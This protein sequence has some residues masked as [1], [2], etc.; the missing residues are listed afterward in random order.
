MVCTVLFIMTWFVISFCFL[1]LNADEH[2]STKGEKRD[3]NFEDTSMH[4]QCQN[5]CTTCGRESTISYEA[6]R[7]QKLHSVRKS[8]DSLQCGHCVLHADNLKCHQCKSSEASGGPTGK[9]L[10]L[11]CSPR[12]GQERHMLSRSAEKRYLSCV[13]RKSFSMSG[14]VALHQCCNIKEM[15]SMWE[16]TQPQRETEISRETTIG[17][18]APG[19]LWELYC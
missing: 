18:N 6:N 3:S 14:H 1:M 8:C 4:T 15:L 11:T 10:S 7:Q 9:H 19:L 17:G 5:H 13:C 16:D 12:E 2:L